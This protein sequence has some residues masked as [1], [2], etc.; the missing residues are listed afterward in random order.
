MDKTNLKKAIIFDCDNT[1][2]QGIV[3]EG[4]ISPDTD[5]QQDIIFLANKGVIIGLCSKNNEQDVTETLKTQFLTEKYISAKRI[6]W[7]DK[8]S[9]L[10]EIA[11]ELN[12]GTDSM[13]FVD[14]SEFER[15]LVKDKLPEVIAIHPRDL[16]RMA[17][18]NFDL[19]GSFTKTQ[20]YKEN[21]Q[22]MR[23]QEQ[24]SDI[25][26]YLASL[27]M[28]LTIKVNDES[29]I[30]RITELTQKTNQFN[31]TTKRYQEEHIREFMK[32]HHV[33][34]LSVKD[35]FGDNGL[36]GVCM[37]KGGIIDTFLLSCRILGRNIEYAF[38]DFVIQDRLKD[39][40]S[41]LIGKYVESPKNGQV[42][43]FYERC[44]FR[45]RVKKNNTET[46]F[47]V[48]KDYISQA[49]KYFRYE[50]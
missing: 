8:V 13:V 29:Q 7:K 27:D 38:I 22:R 20:Q 14:D 36:T 47:L 9:N 3:G 43:G 2:W 21:L 1:L 17:L 48:S 25:E 37:V 28:V 45:W 30:A 23:A 34:S 42:K 26:D 18:D 4:E 40:I 33:Y 39:N 19:S 24:F 41:V 6:N 16:M 50:G 44:G 15:G 49:P 5:I 35:K 12:I 31:L 11:Q 46:Y 32:S 10:K